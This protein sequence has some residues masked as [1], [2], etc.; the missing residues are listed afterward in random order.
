MEPRSAFGRAAT[1]L[2]FSGAWKWAARGAAICAAFATLGLFIVL[3]LFVDLLISRGR[4]AEYTELR[5]SVRAEYDHRATEMSAENRTEL[6]Q[7]LQVP[8]SVVKDIDAN[9]MAAEARQWL[10]RTQ[11]ADLLKSRVG[12]KAAEAYLASNSAEAAPMG[13]LSL[14]IRQP[15]PVQRVGCWIASWNP[16]TWSV[17]GS[18]RNV[19]YLFGLMLIAAV[20]AVL[21]SVMLNLMNYAAATATLDAATRLRRA[22]YQQSY[23]QNTMALRADAADETVE[24]F[25]RNVEDVHNGL[26]AKFTTHFYLPI[27]ML[28]LILAL[29]R[30]CMQQTKRY[31]LMSWL[32]R[33]TKIIT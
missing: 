4:V 30:R 5:T 31:I 13:L 21:R 12:D 18:G 7:K 32:K 26:Y 3:A 24:I 29:A 19:A 1:Y 15:G 23:R 22:V 11:V 16:W 20:L 28:L 14:A 27:L 17:S 2:D 9:P 33:W 6:L 25:S 10:W 8:E